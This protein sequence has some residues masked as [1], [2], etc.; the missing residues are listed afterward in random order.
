M[1]S[2]TTA[3][4]RAIWGSDNAH[5][6]WAVGAGGTIYRLLDPMSTTWAPIVSPTTVN[7]F[8]IWGSAWDDIYVVGASGKIFHYN[9]S[10]S[11]MASPTTQTLYG[12][13]GTGG[14]NWAGGDRVY[15]VGAAGTILQYNGVE[16]TPMTS[17]SERNLYSAWGSSATDVFVAGESTGKASTILRYDGVNWKSVTGGY[18]L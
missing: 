15:A 5:N 6:V 8:G 10:W 14:T 2:T 4:F 7:L 16:W 17:N 12:V 11:E 13:W 18:E 1:S 3:D 9:G